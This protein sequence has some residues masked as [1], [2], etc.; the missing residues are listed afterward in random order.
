MIYTSRVG[1]LYRG[2]IAKPLYGRR[3][4][5]DYRGRREKRLCGGRAAALYGGGEDGMYGVEGAHFAAPI[6]PTLC[7]LC[8]RRD[9]CTIH[10]VRYIAL[11]YA[12]HPNVGIC[13]VYHVHVCIGHILHTAAH[14]SS[15]GDSVYA[16]TEHALAPPSS[17]LQRIDEDVAPRTYAPH[18]ARVRS[19]WLPHTRARSRSRPHPTNQINPGVLVT[20]S[21]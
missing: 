17:R 9:M 12:H 1:A 21:C 11:L 20:K 14:A 16:Y 19:A 2:D 8:S 3:V 4:D 15:Y 7:A 18:L 6:A 13:S 5:V 10:I